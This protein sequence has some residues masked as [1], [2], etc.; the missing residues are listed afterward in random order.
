[1][2]HRLLLRSLSIAALL[3]LCGAP[4]ASEHRGHVVFSGLPVPGATVTASQGEKKFATVT[5][6]SGIY[7]FP[8]LADGIWSVKVE[9]LTFAPQAKEIG[10][11]ANAPTPVWQLA[12]LPLEEMKAV[13]AP[14][15]PAAPAAAI[16]QSVPAADPKKAADKK[17]NDKKKTAAASAP[18]ASF[19]RAD[20][21]ASA[22]M[23]PPDPNG[24]SPADADQSA[25]NPYVVNGSASTGIERR[26]IGNTRRGFRSRFNGALNFVVDNSALDARPLSMTSLDTPR[27]PHNQGQYGVTFGGPLVIPGLIKRNTQFFVSYQAGRTTATPARSPG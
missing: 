25:A 3:C 18:Q 8:D 21:T 26:A 6:D 1:M 15:I 9:M 20:V 7:A 22:A 14:R 19:Q 12:L 16:A 24:L 11:A 2:I 10:V 13:A 23:P 5:D 27:S 17:A 4:S